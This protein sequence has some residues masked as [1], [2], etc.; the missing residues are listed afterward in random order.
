MAKCDLCGSACDI[1][2]MASLRSI[3]QTREVR[4]VCPS[5]ASWAN[6]Q[7]DEV[8]RQQGPEVQARISAKHESYRP[9]PGAPS[10][11]RRAASKLLCFAL[12]SGYAI[13]LGAALH[14]AGWTTRMWQFY[15]VLIPAVILAECTRAAAV[16]SAL[17]SLKS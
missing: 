9:P 10:R 4:D 11:A 12:S 14:A 15:A 13:Y 7:L 2:Y 6:A 8:R 16:R 3:Y 1:V 5:C 17:K